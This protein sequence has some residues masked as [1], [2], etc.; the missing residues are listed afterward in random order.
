MIILVV[1]KTGFGKC[2]I[3]LIMVLL[4]PRKML[5]DD[6][7]FMTQSIIKFILDD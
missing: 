2:T 6:F 7:D 5:L 3:D 1:G 4:R